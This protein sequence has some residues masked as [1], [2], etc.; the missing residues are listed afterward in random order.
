MDVRIVRQQVLEERIHVAGDEQLVAARIEMLRTAS[1]ASTE[2]ATVLRTVASAG[3]V[4]TKNDP[5]SAR[6]DERFGARPSRA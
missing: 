2:G 3:S 4:Q 5:M 6:A 1:T